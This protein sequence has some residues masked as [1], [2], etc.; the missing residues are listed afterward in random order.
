MLINKKHFDILT[1]IIIYTVTTILVTF[2]STAISELL[3]FEKTLKI[4][5]PSTIISTEAD[6]Y[7]ITGTCN[8]KEKLYV[9]NQIITPTNAGLFGIE[10][11]LNS[12]KNIFTFKQGNEEKKVY[13]YKNCSQADI[14]QTT[15]LN[16]KNPNI[17]QPPFPQIYQIITNQKLH[18]S[19]PAPTDAKVTATINGLNFEMNPAYKKSTSEFAQFT[20]EADFKGKE[21]KSDYFNAGPITYTIT[22]DDETTEILSDGY[23]IF[24]TNEELSTTFIEVSKSRASI[25]EKPDI[26]S[27]LLTTIKRGCVLQTDTS[28]TDNENWFKLKD[29]GWIMKSAVCPAN[30]NS[31]IKNSISDISYYIGEN[32][33]QLT[34]AGNC[35]PNFAAAY[36]KNS[37]TVRLYHTKDVDIDNSLYA[38][39][40]FVDSITT[41][42]G[43]AHTDIILK[44]KNG[45]NLLGYNIEYDDNNTI[46][47]LK[48]VPT[49]D[50]EDKPLENTSIMLDAGHGGFD[51]GASGLLGKI[52]GPNEK[53]FN[54]VYTLCLKDKLEERGANVILTRSNNSNISLNN[55]ANKSEE[56]K[57]DFFISLHGDSVD[58]NINP[59]KVRGFS[60]FY[61][62]KETSRTFAQKVNESL[63]K[64]DILPS[65]GCKPFGYYN[66]KNTF[67]PSILIEIGMLTNY[68]DVTELIEEKNIDKFCDAISSAII[69][70]L[71]EKQ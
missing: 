25:F 33:E 37:L 26:N 46:V 7:F 19:C 69:N 67:C 31:S 52:D 12:N 20:G 70:F 63:S 71:E 55:I 32:S 66:L 49:I 36:S 23:I 34:L 56:E 60:V 14:M 21:Y 59:D 8:P 47:S 54:L 40:N 5:R 29:F 61:S 42:S 57:A 48:S 24:S 35:K 68:K 13:I 18:L 58:E 50:D 22:T 43:P 28:E 27:N 1:S 53:D 17:T 30:P 9:N 2:T 51:S 45:Q 4:S 38:K 62:N 3:D 10:V 64:T 6:N 11:P 44:L 16:N 39:S 41:N 65:R 15:T